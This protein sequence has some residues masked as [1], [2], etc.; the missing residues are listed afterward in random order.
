MR[1]FFPKQTPVITS[2]RDYK[3]Y[4]E[5]LFR[6]ELLEE[7]YN[8]NGGSVDCSTFEN[9][10]KKELNQHAPLKPKYTRANNSPFMNKTV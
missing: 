1:A 9:V 5:D 4:N 6:S 2:Y 8:V 10:C 3:Y 7:L